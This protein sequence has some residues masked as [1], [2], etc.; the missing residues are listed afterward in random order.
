MNNIN[1]SDKKVPNALYVKWYSG[2][3][4]VFKKSPRSAM[5]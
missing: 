3:K 2:T 1:F 5:V 4:T